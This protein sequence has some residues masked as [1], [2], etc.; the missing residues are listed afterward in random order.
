MK[1]M[2]DETFIQ[3]AYLKITETENS[4]NKH[5]EQVS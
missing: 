4:M 3:H 1:Y 5:L 2:N